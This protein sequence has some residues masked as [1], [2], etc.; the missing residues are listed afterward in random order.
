MAEITPK[1]TVDI[2]NVARHPTWNDVVSDLKW[3][4]NLKRSF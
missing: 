3:I 2:D 4:N 1:N